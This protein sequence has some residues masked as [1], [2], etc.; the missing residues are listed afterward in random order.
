MPDI[1]T[2]LLDELKQ[3]VGE[4][5]DP[6][7]KAIEEE[8]TARGEVS[9]ETKAAI[10]RV[11]DRLDQIEADA[12]KASLA[13]ARKDARAERTEEQKA[14]EVFVRKNG[15][16]ADEVKALQ[17]GDDTGAGFLAPTEFVDEMLKG[18]VEFSPM[19]QLVRVIST[20][21]SS[22]KFPKRTGSVAARWV[23]ETETKTPSDPSVGLEEIPTHELYA[24][25]DV[26]NWLLED[27][28]FDIEGWL[29]EEVS[30]QFGVAEGTAF[31]TG[32]GSKKP[33]GILDPNSG[34][35]ASLETA[36]SN[37]VA[38]DDLI[39]LFFSLK[40]AYAVNAEWLMNRTTIR[41]VRLLKDAVNGN[42]LWQPGL[43]GVA[44]ATILD[45]PYHDTPD[46]PLASVDDA[47]VAAFGDFR[48]GYIAVDRLQTAV[49]RDPYTQ[50]ADG[51]V[52]FIFRRR[53]GGQTVVPEAI[54]ILKAKA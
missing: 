32:N 30:E 1:D 52:R 29:R 54:K 42:Y 49:Q 21:A 41:D 14:F 23:G 27:A 9:G 34:I 20:S 39:K 50:A 33:E 16:G 19:R 40:G 31:V 25:V 11:N 7:R 51:M 6:L 2:T 15:A 48:R 5:L 10:E 44:P 28:S 36:A 13:T 26:S 4:H 24:M 43:A 37:T 3:T 47:K 22:V 45:R 18:V 17:V 53:L 35:D 46:M 38:A 8:K 12:K